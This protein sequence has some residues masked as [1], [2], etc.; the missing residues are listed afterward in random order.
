DERSPSLAWKDEAE[1]PAS[2][3]AC[4]VYT[5]IQRLADYSSKMSYTNNEDNS[6]D[7]YPQKHIVQ[8]EKGG[9]GLVEQRCQTS[10]RSQKPTEGL[11][12]VVVFKIAHYK[13][14]ISYSSTWRH[15]RV[16][17]GTALAWFLVFYASCSNRP[18]PEERRA[19][20]PS[21]SYSSSPP[22]T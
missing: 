13:E 14:L 16:L 2:M 5:D 20:I 6:T 21:T 15:L 18:D 3:N 8:G 9:K 1:V 22:E 19:M 4:V 10:C 17:R 12:G 11:N 7:D